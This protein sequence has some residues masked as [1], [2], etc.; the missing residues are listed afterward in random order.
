MSTSTPR[1]IE[2]QGDI[3]EIRPTDGFDR[4]WAEQVVAAIDETRTRHPRVFLLAA[5]GGSI[6]PDARKYINEWL[7]ATPA[8][9]ETAIWGGGALHRAI[10]EMITRSVHFFRPGSLQMSFH[11]TREEALSWIAAQRD[12]PRPY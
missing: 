12:K 1:A 5:A 6:T 8:L 2:V 7:R 11:R 9:I 4:A 3:V 10:G